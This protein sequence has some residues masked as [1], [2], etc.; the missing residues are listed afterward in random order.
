MLPAGST[1]DNA[2]IR[3]DP[4]KGIFQVDYVA[5][6]GR[7]SLTDYSNLLASALENTRQGMVRHLLAWDPDDLLNTPTGDVVELLVKRGS[8]HCPRLLTDRAEQLPPTETDQEVREF[9]ERYTRRV[10]RIVLAVPYEGEKVVFTLRANT[11]STNP[12]RVL[13]L[14]DHELHLVVDNPPDDGAQL[15]ANF[16]EQIAHIEKYLS[17]SRE[18]IERHNQQIQNEVPNMVAERREQ[19]LATRNLQADTGYPVRGR[20]DA[21]GS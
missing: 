2:L 4:V 14:Q 9:G 7:G 3:C 19:L 12:P 13:R 20:P 15:K 18:Q 5:L 10:T 17:W 8:A 21:G 11:S 1:E 6:F 16:E